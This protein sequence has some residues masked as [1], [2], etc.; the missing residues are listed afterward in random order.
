MKLDID[1]IVSQ[2]IQ[3]LDEKKVIEEA[4]EKKIESVIKDAIDSAFNWEFSRTISDKIKEQIG[5]IAANIKLNSYNEL[6]ATTVRNLTDAELNKDLAE[7]I[8][9]KLQELM[10][11]TEKSVKLSTIVQKFKDVCLDDEEEYSYEVSFIDDDDNSEFFSYKTLIFTPDS[12]NL[13]NL[14]IKLSKT[15]NQ[16]WTIAS[17]TYDGETTWRNDGLSTLK[18]YNSFE[19]L[20][21]KCMLNNLPVELDLTESG[22]EDILQ[23]YND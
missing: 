4:I 7:K 2:K 22:C 12:D 13:D 6:I 3:E 11:V 1:K 9:N 20:M 15:K 23:N 8:Q 17:V 19:C 16:E 18:H 10:L 5:D 21:W 14:K